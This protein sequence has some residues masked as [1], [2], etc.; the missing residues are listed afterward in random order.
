M[1]VGP[2]PRPCP[3]CPGWVRHDPARRAFGHSVPECAE[4]QAIIARAKPTSTTVD[5][6]DLE[7]G[8]VVRSAPKG[9]A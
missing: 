9:Q 2:A 5:V 4:F 7:T 3:W 6:V 8:E 1:A